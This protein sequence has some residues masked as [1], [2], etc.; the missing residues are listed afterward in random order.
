MNGAAIFSHEYWPG[1]IILQR[2]IR[3]VFCGLE[4]SNNHDEP[5]AAV[6]TAINGTSQIC[7]LLN[8][9]P[10]CVMA[11][12]GLATVPERTT[13]TMIVPVAIA[14]EAAT[15]VTDCAPDHGL[16]LKVVL[17]LWMFLDPF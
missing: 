17:L 13:A 11:G 2:T 5:R 9:R 12:R 16:R 15:A 3:R 14:E 7:D 6:G 10:G 8:A 1:G 4:A